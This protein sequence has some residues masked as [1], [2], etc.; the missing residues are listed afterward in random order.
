MPSDTQAGD[1]RR[2]AGARHIV[3]AIVDHDTIKNQCVGS[4]KIRVRLGEGED[5]EQIKGNLYQ[6]GLDVRE[7]QSNASKRPTFTYQQSLLEK[8]PQR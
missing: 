8:S 5:L 4:G 2:L 6:A 1:L 7:L 3:D